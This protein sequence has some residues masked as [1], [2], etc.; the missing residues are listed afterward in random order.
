MMA[1]VL[2]T[3]SLLLVLLIFLSAFFSASET[4]YTSVSRIKLKSMAKDGNR[5]AVK[6]L[7]M[8][9][10][11][12][13]LISTILIG[14]NTVNITASTLSAWLFTVLFGA[15]LGVPLAT[16]V[17]TLVILTIGEIIPK[18]LARAN[19]ERLSVSLSGSMGVALK[20]FVP[21]TWLFEKLT[22]SLAKRFNGDDDSPS[23]TERELATIVDEIEGEGELEKTERDLIKSAMEFDDKTVDTVVI[24]RVDIVAED[25][26]VSM[27]ELKETF[28]ASGY[29]RV[30]IYDGDIDNIIGVVYAKDFYNK[31]FQGSDFKISDIIRPVKFIPES[32]TLAHALAEIQRSIVQMLV[33]VDSYGGTVGIVSLEDLLEELVGEIWDE[34]DEIRHTV[35]KE[36]DGSYMI[37]GDANILDIMEELDLDLDLDGYDEHSAGGFMQYKLNRVPIKGDKVWVGNALFKIRSVRNHRVRLIQLQI[38]EEPEKDYMDPE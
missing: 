22:S 13:R 10:N 38:T 37:T 24:P 2:I 4:A 5:K 14:N 29:S 3:V 36:S 32:T 8:T 27:E 15:A 7:R 21:L 31:H 19:A 28:L 25:K 30:P 6:V 34:S 11:Y 17:M 1:Q 9:E 20:V 33:V 16:L 12:D 26:S 18:S 35:V 23:F